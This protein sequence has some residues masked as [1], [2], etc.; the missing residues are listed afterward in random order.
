[1]VLNSINRTCLNSGPAARI[2]LLVMPSGPGALSGGEVFI[3]VSNSA[4][5]RGVTNSGSVG[6][7]GIATL[8]MSCGMAMI[9]LQAALS[10]KGDWVC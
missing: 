7:G 10:S 4:G 1:M 9:T 3:S 2:I 5:V 6:V 8:A